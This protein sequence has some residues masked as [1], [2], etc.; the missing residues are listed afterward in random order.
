M[1]IYIY[2]L[3]GSSHAD[4]IF[5]SHVA[6]KY[7]VWLSHHRFVTCWC[8]HRLRSHSPRLDRFMAFVSRLDRQFDA[9]DIGKALAQLHAVDSLTLRLFPAIDEDGSLLAQCP[10]T[11]DSILRNAAVIPDGTGAVYQLGM[12]SQWVEHRGTHRRI[13]DQCNCPTPSP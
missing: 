12:L 1:H 7:D 3:E 10:L 9:E 13:G 4:N 2:G 8:S 6:C 11:C 5:M